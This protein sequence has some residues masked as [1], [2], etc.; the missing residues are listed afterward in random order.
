MINDLPELLLGQDSLQNRTSVKKKI[1]CD[2]DDFE[3][4]VTEDSRNDSTSNGRTLQKQTRQSGNG[5]PHPMMMM[6]ASEN[7]GLKL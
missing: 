5:Q 4:D 7:T 2:F 6:M 3:V 1:I